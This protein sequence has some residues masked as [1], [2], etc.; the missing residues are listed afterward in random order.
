MKMAQIAKQ[1]KS[2]CEFYPKLLRMFS[3]VSQIR[4]QSHCLPHFDS[5]LLKPIAIIALVSLFNTAFAQTHQT[6]HEP[7][8]LA[9]ALDNAN[10]AGLPIHLEELQTPLPPADKN[11]ALLYAKLKK[12]FA[13]L[14]RIT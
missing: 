13:I 11:A 3:C 10:N 7:S 14:L 2:F 8:S 4:D 6:S 5:G 1:I 12:L 9:E